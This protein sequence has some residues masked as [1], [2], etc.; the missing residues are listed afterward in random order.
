M[1]AF[2]PFEQ[3]LIPMIKRKL[4]A[5]ILQSV[6]KENWESFDSLKTIS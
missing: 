6:P 4:L 5:Y 3:T 2:N 1:K